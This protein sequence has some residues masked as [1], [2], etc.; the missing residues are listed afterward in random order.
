MSAVRKQKRSPHWF[1]VVKKPDG[2]RTNISTGI[3]VFATTRELWE[4]QRSRALEIS[5]K[6]NRVSFDARQRG[7]TREQ[8]IEI[9]NEILRT[10]GCD[11]IDTVSIRAFLRDWVGG[12]TTEGTRERYGHVAELFLTHLG[13]LADQSIG[14]VSYQH[15][16]DFIAARKKAGIAPKT[17]KVDAKALNNAFNLARRLGKIS[18]NPV[19]QALALQPIVAES[20]TKGVF[21]RDQIR[22]LVATA[23]GDWKTAV[24]LGY[25]TG[26]R[27]RDCCNLLVSKINWAVNNGVITIRQLKTGEPAWIPIHVCL[28]RHLKKVTE[29][30]GPEDLVCPSLANRKTGGK[31]GLS[32]EFANIMRAAGIDQGRVPGKGKKRFSKLSFHSLRHS[33]NSHLANAGVDQETRQIMTG[34][35]TKAANDDYTHLDLDKLTDAIVR[36]PDVDPPAQPEAA[37]A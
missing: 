1:A 30:L 24:L 27:L 14:K 23:K 36:L 2:T 22:L 26:A 28:A 20:S 3:L 12:K 17:I 11:G 6:L 25:Y 32:R 19:D 4:Q 7:L 15:I 5:I 16:L 33:F 10:A 35:A 18:V 9:V 13:P 31:T 34:Q 8:L 21:T 37:A 29:G